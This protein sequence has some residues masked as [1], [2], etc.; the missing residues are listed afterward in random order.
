MSKDADREFG[1]HSEGEM[2]LLED[3]LA[4]RDVKSVADL[5]GDSAAPS[6]SALPSPAIGRGIGALPFVHDAGSQRDMVTLLLCKFAQDHIGYVEGIGLNIGTRMVRLKHLALA[7]LESFALLFRRE[8]PSGN[9]CGAG[10]LHL[11]FNHQR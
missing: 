3:V 7:M 2:Q 10:A 6:A 9:A 4:R 1:G 8:L 5:P 11:A